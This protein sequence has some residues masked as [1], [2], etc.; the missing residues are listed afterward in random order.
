MSK[1]KDIKDA[2]LSAAARKMFPPGADGK[3]A[4]D[5]LRDM[6]DGKDPKAGGRD[7]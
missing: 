6:A 2:L 3:K 7:A 5:E 1:A 4:A